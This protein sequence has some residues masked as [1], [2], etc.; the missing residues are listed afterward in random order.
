MELILEG[1]FYL[2]RFSG[3]A[4]WTYIPF[5]K[6]NISAKNPFGMLKVSGSIDEYQFKD[7]HLMPIG[8]GRLFLP[9]AKQVRK[10]IK[11]EAGD[12]VHLK[13]YR[14][15]LPDSAPP[16]LLDC[17]RDDPGKLRLFD[18]IPTEEKEKWVSFIYSANSEEEKAT[19]IVKLLE[20]L[21]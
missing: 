5:S 16:E 12:S 21:N 18:L 17:L 3:K 20:A 10:K 13:L 4:G 14:Q 11:K 1:D 9:L 19:R 15:A 6:E 8:D 7:K 2:E